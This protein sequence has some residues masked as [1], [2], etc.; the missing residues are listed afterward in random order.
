MTDFNWKINKF[1]TSSRARTGILTTP[2]GKINTPAF[3]FCAT[4]AALKTLSTDEVEKLETQI[5][6]SNTYHLM[7]QPGEKIIAKH[8]GLHKFMNW[9]GPTLTDSG[10]FQIFSLGHGSVADEI[11]GKN[12]NTQRNKSL[13]KISEEG[14][15]FKSYI[16]G[17]KQLLTP[18]RS[19]SI[20]KKIGADFILVFDECTPYHVDKNYTAVSLERS[21]R[22]SK[23][24]LDVYYSDKEFQTQCGSSG[25][26][27][28]YGIIQGGIYED[29][30]KVS[31][32][33]NLE[34][35]FF[36]LA[37]GGSL[38]SSKEQMNDIVQYTASNLDNNHPV[39]LLGIGD[40][41]DIWNFVRWGIDTFDCVNPT[42]LARHGAV[43]TRNKKGKINIKNK[44]YR[45][46]FNKLDEICGCS[47]C[48]NYTRSYLHHLFKIN[49]ILGL[50]LLTIHNIYF[51]NRM[52]QWIRDAINNDKLDQA[53][54]EWFLN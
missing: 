5:I 40:Q 2:H 38:G 18:E 27:A 4:K 17:S 16:D 26:Q 10:G 12:F 41:V 32:D 29:L 43:L 49:E 24:S 6:L 37:I 1:E 23:R 46:D 51:M 8:G 28:L 50:Q 45:E 44:T 35:N 47:T 15:L 22:W 3:V 20:Q 9:E 31:I 52:M 25:K 53:Q 21:H 19:I 36:G 30:R 13:I 14:A 39:H 42:R 33:F 54:S 48:N 11:K 34:N 7:L